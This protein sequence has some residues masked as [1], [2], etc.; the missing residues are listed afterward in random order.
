M[1]M[2]EENGMFSEQGWNAKGTVSA[3]WKPTEDKQ[4][5]VCLALYVIF[6]SLSWLFP[7]I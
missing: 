6:C 4:E 7:S 1:N 5:F 3:P 2:G